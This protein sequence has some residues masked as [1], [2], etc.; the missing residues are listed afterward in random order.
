[1]TATREDSEPASIDDDGVEIPPPSHNKDRV[2]IQRLKN[3]KAAEPGGLPAELFKA[4]GDELV[5][6]MHQLNNNNN[7]ILAQQ[8]K[9]SKA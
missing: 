4:G 9:S 7:I 2:A 1:M 8:P 5:K 6:R 3:N